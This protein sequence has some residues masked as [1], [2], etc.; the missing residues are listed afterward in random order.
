M[1]TGS[2]LSCTEYTPDGTALAVM[3]AEVCA[4]LTDERA[5]TILSYLRQR[6]PVDRTLPR[7]RFCVVGRMLLARGKFAILVA[8]KTPH[9]AHGSSI[10]PD[11]SPSFL[12]GDT[13]ALQVCLQSGSDTGLVVR[14]IFSF[15]IPSKPSPLRS[16][17]ERDQGV[18]SVCALRVT[19]R[20]AEIR[21]N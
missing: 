11:K 16:A 12:S 15:S 7:T 8:E 20:I 3:P 5:A 13:D 10:A 4:N 2:A 18:R 6:S 17:A 21:T 9:V 1:S 14:D 19:E